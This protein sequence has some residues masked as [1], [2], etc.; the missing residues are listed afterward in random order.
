MWCLKKIGEKD[1]YS[2]QQL[3]EI[4]LQ[5]ITEIENQLLNILK[6]REEIQQKV[7]SL[8]TNN[9]QKNFTPEEIN[10]ITAVSQE[11]A[12]LDLLINNLE[13]RWQERISLLGKVDQVGIYH[14]W[15]PHLQEIITT[16]KNKYAINFLAVEYLLR[17]IKD[18]RTRADF[19]RKNNKINH[20][21]DQL[22]LLEEQAR[23]YLKVKN[24]SGRVNL[25]ETL[26]YF[27]VKQQYDN[28]SGRVLP[29]GEKINFRG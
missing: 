11:A 3:K 27:Y 8:Q 5:T 6:K 17:L 29:R 28:N 15:A 26:N 25:T 2:I 1:N 14:P 7:L 12:K 20:I 23:V 16:D 10:K 22:N 13:L 24:K 18:D 19:V 4:A 9:Q 21:L